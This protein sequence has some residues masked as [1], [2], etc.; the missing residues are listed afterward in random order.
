MDP[1][2]LQTLWFIL[3]AVLWTGFFFLE[4]F[5]Y[6][7]GILLPFV[8]KD[9]VDRRVVI[10]TIGPF[11]DGNEVWLLTAGGAT[12][13]AFPHWYATMF[14][15][16]YLALAVLLIAL[17]MR[18]VAFEFRSKD[19]KSQWRAFWDWAIFGGSLVPALLMG[20]AF[21]NLLQGVPINEKMQF[22]GNFFSLL[23]PYTLIT[24]LYALSLM[25]IHGAIYLS[26]KAEGEVAERAT[27][28]AQRLWLP[29]VVIL[30]LTI[31][32]SDLSTDMFS[33]LGINPGPIPLTGIATLLATGW[34]IR[35][36]RPGWAF[37]MTGV[38]IAT[39]VITIFMTLFP[40]VM[41]SS[42]N[43]AYSLTIQ[44]ASSTPY[45]L[46]VMTVVAVIFVPIVLGYQ[47]WTYYTFRKRVTRQS[48]QPQS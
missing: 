11:W 44:N 23:S 29:V 17:I 6:G 19:K 47:A 31:L 2:F 20:V 18:G 14:S 40:R 26:M 27:K 39:S 45:T 15:G 32:M 43:P 25:T 42:T 8:A 28:L 5:D 13:A 35:N 38:T 34:F 24:G 7:V 16:F 30:G 36:K 33:K 1:E 22:T 21:G 48:V 4:G 37:A 10:N 41:V 12:F 9:D 46:S 3:I